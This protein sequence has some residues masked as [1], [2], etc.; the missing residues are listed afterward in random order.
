MIQSLFTYFGHGELPYEKMIEIENYLR[1]SKFRASGFDTNCRILDCAC[2]IG[3]QAI[4]LASLGYNVTGSDIS[5]KEV[6][7]AKWEAIRRNLNIRFA[8]TDFRKLADAFK[9]KFD[10]IIHE[11]IL[12]RF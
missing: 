8:Y 7:E 12:S 11:C 2:G 5:S 10:I 4:G 1:S 9:D 3:T 6:V